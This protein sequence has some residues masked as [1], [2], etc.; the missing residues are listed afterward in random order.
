MLQNFSKMLQDLQM[1][2]MPESLCMRNIKRN[3]FNLPEQYSEF[4]FLI[5]RN[6]Y[7]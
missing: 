4:D 7:I 6:Y 1:K 2:N 3:K 5:I